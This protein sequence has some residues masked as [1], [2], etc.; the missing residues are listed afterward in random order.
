[1]SLRYRCFSDDSLKHAPTF[2][3]PVLH[4]I[5]L[6]GKSMEMLENLG[7]KAEFIEGKERGKS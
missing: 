5:I 2:L 7:R 6:A 3:L 4:S 1:M